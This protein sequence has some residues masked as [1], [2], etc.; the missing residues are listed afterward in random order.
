METEKNFDRLLQLSKQAR[1]LEGVSS[2]LDWDQETYMPDGAS[3][4][5]SEQVKTLAGV[6]HRIKTGKKFGTA[7][8]K[9]IDV[10]KGSYLSKS[11]SE[12]QKAALREWRRDYLHNTSLPTKFIEDFT[13]LTSQAIIAW[14]EAKEQDSFQHFAPS[15]EKIVTMCRR[16]ADLLGYKEHPYDALLDLYEPD[17][18]TKEVSTLF[19]GLRLALSPLIK[20][21]ENHPVDH[22]FLFGKWDK[23][24]QL[25]FGKTLLD[26]MGYS[27][28]NGRL[29]C[30]VHPF[31]S[32]SHPTDSRITTRIHPTSLMSSIFAVLHE[33]GHG[34]YEMG[35]PVEWYGNPLG[36]ARSLGVHESQS[37]WWETRIGLSRPFWKY[38]F[39]QLQD[40]FKGPLKNVSFE[41][42]YRGI[43][44]VMPSFIRIEA[45]EMTYPMHVILRFELEKG[46]IEGTL[47]VKD[48]PEAWNDTMERYLGITPPS[49]QQGCLQ[50]IHWSMG[51]FGY[52]PTY[53]LG[54]IYA[55]HLFEA[56]EKDQPQWEKEVEKGELLFIKNW[57]AD[58]I[59]R[60]GSFYSTRDLLEKASK[61][62]LSSKAYLD[63]LTKKFSQLYPIG[64]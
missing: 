22:A 29:D 20:K 4:I 46:L 11:F 58:K 35:L 3:G 54:N 60:H 56:F 13:K 59:Y 40:T 9:L 27:F 8:N 14:R 50:D 52:F 32:S 43:N 6:I 17:M 26:H 48:I 24:K 15:L 64:H 61:K 36:N 51:G 41:Q 39:P 19:D 31:S 63:Y 44:K 7:L 55:A 62:K 42:F 16:K 33:G 5:R 30:S 21:I 18:T 38:F 10:N 23:T 53:T 57:L 47:K 1:I 12:E 37:R 45:D 2:I 25:A 34:L 28:T 49:F